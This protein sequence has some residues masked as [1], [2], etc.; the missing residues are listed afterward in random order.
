LRGIAGGDGVECPVL[1]SRGGEPA[2]IFL[3][4]Y[5]FR[6]TIWVELGFTGLL[7]ERGQAYAAPD[8]PYGRATG[9]TRRTR[10]VDV[11]LAIARDALRLAGATRPAVTFAASM[12]GRYAVYLASEGL[13]DAL[14]LAAPALG[15]DERAWSLLRGLRP[16]WAVVAWGTR[17]RVVSRGEAEEVARRLGARLVVVEGASH[18]AYRDKL[19]LFMDL[20]IE[21]IEAA[22]NG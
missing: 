15:R 12:G 14:L 8:M 17:D 2:V 16:R 5:S 4:G 9:C 18:A 19:G 6:H 3:H 20:L 22:T 13:V 7:E 21:A 10:S 1:Y 11:N